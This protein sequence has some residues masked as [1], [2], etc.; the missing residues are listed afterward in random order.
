[1]RYH[2]AMGTFDISGS[3]PLSREFF[4]RSARHVAP[5]LLGCVV[6]STAGGT[7]TAGRI[8]EVEAYLG[9]DDPGSHAATKQVTQRNAVMYGAAGTVYVYFTY[10]NHHM[11]NLVCGPQGVAGAVLLRALEPV[12]GIDVM[13]E[14]RNGVALHDLANGPGKLAVAL[15]IDLSDNGTT[16]GEGRITVYAGERRPD[17]GIGVSGRVGLS[18]GHELELRY[19]LEGNRYVSRGR[20]GR[21]QRRR[22]TE[23]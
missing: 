9:S 15:G 1:M 12:A 11:L 2:E 23:S 16:L 22:R 7:L 4:D 8:V 17:E 21:A 19:F 6:A 14:R 13:T 20:A 18:A 5:D 10:G 3:M